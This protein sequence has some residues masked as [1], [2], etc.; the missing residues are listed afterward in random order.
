MVLNPD[1]GSHYI[2]L[3]IH[4]SKLIEMQPYNIPIISCYKEIMEAR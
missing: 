1:Q 3:T 2:V 4:L